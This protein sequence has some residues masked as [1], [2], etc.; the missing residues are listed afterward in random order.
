MHGAPRTMELLSRIVNTTRLIHK[1]HANF[2]VFY[3][4]FYTRA[5]DLD[6]PMCI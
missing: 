1:Y 5:H 4:T 3:I 6:I 2:V